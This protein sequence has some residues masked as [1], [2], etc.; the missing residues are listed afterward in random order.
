ML[1]VSSVEMARSVEPLF[2]ANGKWTSKHSSWKGGAFRGK[3]DP[4]IR[5]EANYKRNPLFLKPPKPF[6]R[7]KLSVSDHDFD[8]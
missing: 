3:P 1:T 8:V 5:A 7:D 6:G 2:L 4:T